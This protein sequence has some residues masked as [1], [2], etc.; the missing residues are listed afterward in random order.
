M[1]YCELLDK[2]NYEIKHNYPCITINGLKNIAKYIY[3]FLLLAYENNLPIISKTLYNTREADLDKENI[4]YDMHQYR[5][6]ILDKKQIVEFRD[7][8]Y[9][10]FTIRSYRRADSNRPVINGI[11]SLCLGNEWASDDYNISYHDL[12]DDKQTI[13]EAAVLAIREVINKIV[14]NPE[15]EAWLILQ[16]IYVRSIL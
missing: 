1:K 5:I 10:Q 4:I 15:L 12:S 9:I 2:W 8:S 14:A 7:V 16:N 11:Y 6:Q 3:K 13:N